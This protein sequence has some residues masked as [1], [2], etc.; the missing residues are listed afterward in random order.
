MTQETAIMRI[1]NAVNE[2]CKGES[3]FVKNYFFDITL[4]TFNT[5]ENDKHDR[6][7]D[8]ENLNYA[9]AIN[10]EDCYSDLLVE[11][12][13]KAHE[14]EQRE[15]EEEKERRY[16]IECGKK[17]IAFYNT[18]VV[19][20]Q[21]SYFNSDFEQIVKWFELRGC[22]INKDTLDEYDTTAPNGEK[23]HRKQVD[24]LGTFCGFTLQEING[25]TEIGYIWVFDDYNDELYIDDKGEVQLW[26]R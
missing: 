11:A 7:A 4:S 19:D 12:R 17:E 3:E 26:Q 20:W 25:E 10:L 23:Q 24:I 14:K 6:H 9:I 16:M 2:A 13:E 1:R 18:L 8:W 22:D 21:S 15:A 5:L